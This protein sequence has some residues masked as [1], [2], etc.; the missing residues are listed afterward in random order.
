M[1]DA[2]ALKMMCHLPTAM[3][4]KYRLPDEGDHYVL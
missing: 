2:A 1:Q 4:G 3:F